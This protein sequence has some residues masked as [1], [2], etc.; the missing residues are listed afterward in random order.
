MSFTEEFVS[1]Y[2]TAD[3]DVEKCRTT[4][5]VADLCERV[6]HQNVLS[7]A[8]VCISTISKFISFYYQLTGF[9]LM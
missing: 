4:A 3:V 8:F 7:F 5:P 1:L 6:S 2:E 9:I